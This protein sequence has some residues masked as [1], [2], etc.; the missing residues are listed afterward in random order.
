MA[1]TR[2]HEYTRNLSA[3]SR[4]KKSVYDQEYAK[5]NVRRVSIPFNLTV[6]HD[7]KLYEYLGTVDNKTQYI[8]DL[9][10][11]DMAGK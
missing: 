9:V 3:E 2:E 7:A 4:Q 10:E 1:I 8:K 11:N 6:E 5:Q